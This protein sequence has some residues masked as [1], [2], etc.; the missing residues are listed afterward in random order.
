MKPSASGAKVRLVY[1]KIR[2]LTSPQEKSNR[3]TTY[4]AV[5]PATE[6]LKIGTDGNLRA[7][8]PEHSA[9]K[10]SSVHRAIAKTIERRPDRFSQMN[11][12]FL[13]AASRA[14]VDDTQKHVDLWDASV[15]NGA[16]SQG[17]IRRWIDVCA[18]QGIE[19]GEFFVRAEISVEPDPKERVEIAIARNTTTR[20]RDITQA[21]ARGHLTELD[22]AFKK[23]FPRRKLAMSETDEGDEFVDT[24]SLLQVLWALMPDELMPPERKS[25][26]ARMRS[27]KNAAMC[28]QDFI[29][30]REEQ[31]EDGLARDRY[32]YFI[33]MAGPAWRLYE[34]WRINDGRWDGLR[35]KESAKHVQRDEEGEIREVADGIVFPVLAGYSNFVAR[36]AK[37][38]KWALRVPAAMRAKDMATY[39]R[40]LLKQVGGK[41][42]LMGRSGVAYEALMTFTE[43]ANRNALSK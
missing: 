38:K 19:P 1:E 29:K 16:Q 43:F 34:E 10:R 8:I 13:I 20:V 11:S 3:A 31:S 22:E 37:T 15:N 23:E 33:Q 21:G 24:E 40:R 14:E 32:S 5:L 26:E 36:D 35:L 41:P 25:I 30:T 9:K 28:L 42:M 27:Y 17:E 18:A 6:I 12:G 4:F 2:D 39:A 7:Y